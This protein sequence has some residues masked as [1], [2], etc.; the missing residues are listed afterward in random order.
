[1]HCSSPVLRK[2]HD[3]FKKGNEAA[4]NIKELSVCADCRN[5]GFDNSVVCP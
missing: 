4:F 3:N 5:L 1:M 2:V